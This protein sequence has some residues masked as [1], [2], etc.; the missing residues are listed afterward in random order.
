MGRAREGG[1]GRG[2]GRIE[3][4]AGRGRRYGPG[5][6]GVANRGES[7][8]RHWGID[9]AAMRPGRERGRCCRR[10]W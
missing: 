2:G 7:L 3:N 1:K 6:G 8:A 4:D 9:P 5:M 10:N